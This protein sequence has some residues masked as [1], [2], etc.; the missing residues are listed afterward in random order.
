M[1]RY[2]TTKVGC[3]GEIKG[4]IHSSNSFPFFILS[5][6]L[7]AV[8]AQP[9]W[10]R[11]GVYAVY[12]FN[13]AYA[14]EG[15]GPEGWE[16]YGVGG[17]Y[18]RWEVVKVD[19]RL[20]VLNITLKT[21]DL[22]RRVQV[23]IDTETMDLIEDGRVWGK[24]WLWINLAKLPASHPDNMVVRNIT[25]IMN[26]LNETLKNPNVSRI[27]SVSKETFVKHPETGLG[28]VD[29]VVTISVSTN[30]THLKIGNRTIKIS[31]GL[32]LAWTNEVKCGLLVAG[33]Y[34]DDILSQK[35][36]I[37]YLD[38]MAKKGEAVHWMILEDTNLAIGVSG[39]A[40]FLSIL[41]GY[42]IYILF[43]VLVI[44]FIAAFLRGR[45]WR[46]R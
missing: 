8:D 32:T 12:R 3:D 17:G 46:K 6:S 22:I 43:G 23:T 18:Y 45:V 30:V 26:W 2:G 44:L 4:A 24:A 13:G 37:V 38:D 15:W 20:A 11:E 36:G 29:E 27:Y 16:L 31:P 34:M 40:D 35:F 42:Y 28:T 39:G 33:R 7:I 41:E 9:F 25:L 14:L 19:G 10:L 21:G 5:F 1:L